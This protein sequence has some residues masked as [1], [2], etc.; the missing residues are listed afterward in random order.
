MSEEADAKQPPLPMQSTLGQWLRTCA[1]ATDLE[2]ASMLSMAP[3]MVSTTELPHAAPGKDQTHSSR[4][5][6]RCA[7]TSADVL[8]SWLCQEKAWRRIPVSSRVMPWELLHVLPTS[9]GMLC[10][11]VG[12]LC[13]GSQRSAGRRVDCQP[14]DDGMKGEDVGLKKVEVPPVKIG[15]ASDLGAGS[16]GEAEAA[17]WTPRSCKAFRTSEGMT[18]LHLP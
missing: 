7:P 2:V 10:K 11:I 4:C 3:S 1:S 17:Q 6:P 12:T 8:R 18:A 14:G 5:S 15:G 13:A 9:R 16:T